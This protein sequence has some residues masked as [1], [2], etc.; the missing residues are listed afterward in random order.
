VGQK[1]NFEPAGKELSAMFGLF[2]ALAVWFTLSVDSRFEEEVEAGDLG[3]I[4]IVTVYWRKIC[5]L[6][7]L[8][9]IV[10]D[11]IIHD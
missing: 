4:V 10:D 5:G 1:F 6:S 7:I 11:Q 8:D 3:R 2:F 9:R